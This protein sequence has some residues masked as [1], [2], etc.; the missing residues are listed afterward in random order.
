MRALVLALI[1][2][3]LLC[4]P[5]VTWAQSRGHLGVFI[6]NVTRPPEE[7]GKE[8]GEGVLILGLMRHGPR[9]DPTDISHVSGR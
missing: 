7:S 2:C 1:H 5:E 6:Q 8:A 3:L 9:G 4:W